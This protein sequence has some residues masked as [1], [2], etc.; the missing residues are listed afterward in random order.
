[1]NQAKAYAN[2]NIAVV[3]YWGKNDRPLN[4][5]CVSSL[6]M[7][8]R[9]FGTTV[10]LSRSSSKSHES[11]IGNTPAPLNIAQRTA[12]YLEQIRKL[13]NFDGFLRVE[14]ESNIP[15]ASG[16]ASS[17]SFF[18]ALATAKNQLFQL[19]L[20]AREQSML[21]RI[22]SG[23]AARSILGGFVGLYGGDQLTHE[24]AYAFQV[25][26]HESLD[27]AMV[28][29]VVSDQKKPISSR[30]A[31]TITK[32]TSP[33]FRAFVDAQEQDF[34]GSMIALRDGSF[35]TLGTIME[36]STLK[37]FAT[38]WTAQP[39]IIYWHP[40]TLA[41]INLIYELRRTHG[42]VA[43][44]TMDA[45]PNVKILCTQS[46]LPELVRKVASAELT[47]TIFC[48]TPGPGSHVVSKTQSCL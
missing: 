48:A 32:T 3:K 28:I 39:A 38:M 47:T 8:L 7:T 46:I 35:E 22:G 24:E 12:Q 4:I 42:P 31:M 26:H 14:T 29:A 37:M 6:S 34:E 45:G 10:S 2:A 33:F 9:D 25:P 27:L 40:Q 30:D 20:D 5:P 44:F 15:L 16:L 18:A 13:H 43:Y 1:M 17:A 21:A 36:H 19:S 23:S 11:F 41:L